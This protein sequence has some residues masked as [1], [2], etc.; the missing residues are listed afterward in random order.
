M[1][2]GKW[3]F[4]TTKW[5]I[6]TVLL[7]WKDTIESLRDDDSEKKTKK[8]ASKKPIKKAPAKKE[9]KDWDMKKAA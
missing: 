2:I 7:S 9:T 5:A 1:D 3:W 4:H 6:R 8:V